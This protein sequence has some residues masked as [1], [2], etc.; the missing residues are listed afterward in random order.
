METVA[1]GGGKNGSKQSWGMCGQTKSSERV[2]QNAAA[3]ITTI[4]GRRGS[5]DAT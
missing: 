2:N 5:F 1:S 4:T 3:V